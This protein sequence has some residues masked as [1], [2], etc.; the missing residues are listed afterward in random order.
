MCISTVMLRN[1]G[2]IL[3]RR[4]H[5]T[6]ALDHFCL[7][8]LPS[9]AF[10]FF[11]AGDFSIRLNCKHVETTEEECS[12]PCRA[13]S[14]S[15]SL[16]QLMLLLTRGSVHTTDSSQTSQ[17]AAWSAPESLS[18][19]KEKMH[20]LWSKVLR[21]CLPVSLKQ[22]RHAFHNHT[23]HAAHSIVTAL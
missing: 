4:R 10:Y 15:A 2:V 14:R 18:A 11:G 1:F 22:G 17:T 12:F 16:R 8:G 20:W 5:Q 3:L 19:A 6:H 9:C 13:C 7:I 21:L 23:L